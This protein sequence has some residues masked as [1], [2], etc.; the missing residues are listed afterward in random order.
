LLTGLVFFGVF[1]YFSFNQ[2]DGPS[3]ATELIETRR[4]DLLTVRG[5]AKAGNQA[6]KQQ[7][8]IQLYQQRRQDEPEKARLH[9]ILADLWFQT[10]RVDSAQKYYQSGLKL[11]SKDSFAQWNLTLTYLMDYQMDTVR[12][13][14]ANFLQGED[15]YLR[16]KAEI[17]NQKMNSVDFLYNLQNVTH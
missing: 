5:T 14:L 9:F 16:K 11:D 17:L 10:G 12:D 8:K 6:T 1:L 7:A 13:H 3:V 4:V 15:A 2:A